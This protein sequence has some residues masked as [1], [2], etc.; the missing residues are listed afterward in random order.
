MKS[1]GQHTHARGMALIEVV[2]AM[3]IMSMV[4]VAVWSSFQTTVKAI[5]LSEQSYDRYQG[6]RGALN[7]M[8]NEISLSYLSFNRPPDEAKHYTL[9][10]GRPG[11][12]GPTLTF[13]AFAHLRVRK[14]AN[15]SDQSLIQY[16]VAQDPNDSGRKHLF[17]RETPRL[18][19][20]LPEELERY[21]PAYI[22][23][24]DVER[25]EFMFWDQLEEDW[26]PEWSTVSNDAQ[27][28]RLPQ[29]VM[30]SLILVD[31]E[32]EESR[33]TTQTTIYMQEKLNLS[34][35]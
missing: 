30:I 32:G 35:S 8:A 23:C 11:A 14:H 31:D 5:E 34:Q 22:L 27:P 12:E 15:E 16:F 20:D 19:G 1:P 7:R 21:A 2:V 9:F 25:I 6:I 28:D 3:A 29:R 17:R 24:E 4:V 26:R 18:T 10:E 33:F 13:S